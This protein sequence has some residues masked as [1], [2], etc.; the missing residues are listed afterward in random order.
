MLEI[1]TAVLIFSGVVLVLVVLLM[2]AKTKLVPAGEA[3]LLIN[4][5]H[6]N[7]LKVPVG[8]TLLAA[9]TANKVFIPSACGGKG[10]CGV[11]E[12]T[13]REGGG[14]LLPTETGFIKPGEARRGKRLACQVKVKRDLKIEL[15]P[16]I[17]CVQ[18]RS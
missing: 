13:V 7:A 6:G 12:V 2:M 18:K 4:D 17:F 11:C 14:T 3:M 10:S 16:E 9:L 8:G 15:P 5:D 1:F